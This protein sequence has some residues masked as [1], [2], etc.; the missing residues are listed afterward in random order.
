MF[1][2]PLECISDIIEPFQVS[3][4]IF[5]MFTFFKAFYNPEFTALEW[6]LAQKFKNTFENAQRVIEDSKNSKN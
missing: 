5:S 2:T 1:Q 4:M 3:Q 6:F